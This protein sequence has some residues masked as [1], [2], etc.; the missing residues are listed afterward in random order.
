MPLSRAEIFAEWHKIHSP[1]I[2]KNYIYDVVKDLYTDRFLNMRYK[3]DR[4][5]SDLQLNAV[6]G[7]IILTSATGGYWSKDERRSAVDS[8]D[9][10][11]DWKYELG[12]KGLLL[13]LIS[14]S[15]HNDML[16]KERKLAA[17]KT[18][19]NKT[20]NTV[21]SNTSNNTKD[22]LTFLRLFE[23]FDE[24]YDTKTKSKILEKIAFEL[25]NLVGEMT[26]DFLRNY[27]I[28]RCYDEVVIKIGEINKSDYAFSVVNKLRRIEGEM[29][30]DEEETDE[31][32]TQRAIHDLAKLKNHKLKIL[33]KLIPIT[34]DLL[35]MM[36]EDRLET[37]QEIA[38]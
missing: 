36:K 37:Q 25:E 21:V 28:N 30:P 16:K 2:R 10:E 8:K 6:R 20:M 12:L 11:K 13:Y 9:D 22:D 4:K 27:I 35:V 1:K 31:S 38:S 23:I 18:I 34:E 32:D 5:I 7:E 29:S 19:K 15:K 33:D 24:I 3:T 26:V 17:N 14:T